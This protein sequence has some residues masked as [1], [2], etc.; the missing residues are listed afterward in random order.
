M[1]AITSAFMALPD[2]RSS[3]DDVLLLVQELSNAQK[4]RFLKSFQRELVRLRPY[5]QNRVETPDKLDDN[6]LKKI[7]DTFSSRLGRAVVLENTQDIS[8]IGGVRVVIGDRRWER[9]IN[10]CLQAF[11]RYSV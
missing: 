7:A 8:L 2:P 5:V 1:H 11:A 9:S 10:A 4:V 3:F 6:E